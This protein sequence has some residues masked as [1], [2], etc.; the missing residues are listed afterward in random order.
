VNGRVAGG[1][2]GLAVSS[3]GDLDLDN[4]EGN[5]VSAVFYIYN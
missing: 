5:R 3:V 2:F 4:F 1:L